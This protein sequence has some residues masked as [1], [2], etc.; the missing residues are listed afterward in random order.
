MMSY[1]N[2]PYDTQTNEALN[3]VIATVTPKSVCYSGSISLFSRIALV[4]GIHNMGYYNFFTELFQRVGVGMTAILA[5]FLHAKNERKD[6]KKVYERRLDIKVKRSKQQ[7][8]QIQEI[9]KERTDMSYGHAVGIPMD[10]SKKRKQ[11]SDQNNPLDKNI[12][13]KKCKCGS[14]T[15]SR[16]SHKDCPRNPKKKSGCSSGSKQ[17]DSTTPK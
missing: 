3:Q 16:V 10:N 1:C 12:P 13:Q 4:I 6:R 11:N 15:H 2:H 7:K 17:C 5:K 8:K 9:Y 14:T